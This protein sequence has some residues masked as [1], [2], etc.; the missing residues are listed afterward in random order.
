MPY[1]LMT[2]QRNTI[3]TDSDGYSG[4]INFFCKKNRIHQSD[5]LFSHSV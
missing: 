5:A 2:I 3:F 1:N 4:T